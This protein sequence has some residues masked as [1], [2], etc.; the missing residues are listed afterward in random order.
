[1]H[2]SSRI[3]RSRRC[4]LDFPCQVVKE[5][6]PIEVSHGP[7]FAL[8]EREL[9]HVD[10]WRR[11]G[12]PKDSRQVSNAYVLTPENPAAAC[13]GHIGRPAKSYLPKKEAQGVQQ[14]APEA[15]QAATTTLAAIAQQRSAALAAQWR[16]RCLA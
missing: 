3:R 4:N 7:T 14:V 12:W 8:I 9:D 13:D 15:R 10:W 16:R 6:N 2:R 1:M 11:A 5:S